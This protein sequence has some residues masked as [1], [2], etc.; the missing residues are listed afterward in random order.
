MDKQARI[1]RARAGGKARGWEER[2][3]ALERYNLQP[4]FCLNCGSLIEVGDRR[5]ADVIR[6]KFCN[7]SC[8]ATYNNIKHPDRYARSLD[9]VI[10]PGVA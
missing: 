2:K 10:P 3:R 5:V 7:S 6:K 1:D 4:H 9:T 8:S